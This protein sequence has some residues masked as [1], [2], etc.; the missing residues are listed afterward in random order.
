MNLI[1]SGTDATTSNRATTIA[2]HRT[3]TI[4]SNRTTTIT[5][6]R[7]IIA[8]TIISGTV[9]ISGSIRTTRATTI[10][11]VTIITTV[12]ASLVSTT[13]TTTTFPRVMAYPS[14]SETVAAF[15]AVGIGVSALLTF[16][17]LNGNVETQETGTVKILDGISGIPFILKFDKSVSYTN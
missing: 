9:T 3:T 6:H 16:S 2:S 17:A 13:S 14:T 1:S 12:I 15:T 11:P 10:T 7:T 8:S 4:T 5:S